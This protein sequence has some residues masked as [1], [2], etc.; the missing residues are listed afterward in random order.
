[1]RNGCRGSL[2]SSTTQISLGRRRYR[3]HNLGYRP[4]LFQGDGC[5]GKPEFAP[6]EAILVTAAAPVVPPSLVNQLD[7]GG[8]LVIPL[9]ERHRQQMTRI[10]K[11][12]EG[13]L[14]KE[15][16]LNFAFVPLLGEKGWKN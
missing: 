15:L 8:R 2:V 3:L 6:Y 12:K 13:N 1:M 5:K 11:D 9:G 14:T 7:T 10:T 4:H 16:F